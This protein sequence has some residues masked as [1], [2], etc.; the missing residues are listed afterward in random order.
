MS[1]LLGLTIGLAAAQK[2]RG[3]LPFVPY[4]CAVPTFP[5]GSLQQEFLPFSLGAAFPRKTPFKGELE[6]VLI[7][8]VLRLLN[9]N[10]RLGGC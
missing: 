9:A 10:A 2:G 8:T 1:H 3:N 5:A 6:E 4:V 7:R